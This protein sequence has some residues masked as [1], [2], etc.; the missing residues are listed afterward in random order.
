MTQAMKREWLIST[1]VPVYNV[2]SYI[3]QTLDSIIGQT[4]GFEQNV[5]L[6]IIDD[7]STDGSDEICKEFAERYPD[8]IEYVKQENAGVSTAR[9]NGLHLAQGEY[10]HFLDS[11]DVI[12]ND[13]YKRGI[14]FLEENKGA[15]DFV[16]AK[17]RF[18][19]GS[20]DA[21]PN[22]YKFERQRVINVDEEPDNP[23]MHVSSCIFV[24]NAVRN[25]A[26]DTKLKIAE[27]AKF[28]ADVLR[29]K[30][31]YGVL[32]KSALYY[33]KR[34][35]NS[36]AI[37]GQ[38]RNKSFYTVTPKRFLKHLL[39]SWSEGGRSTLYAQCVVLYDMHWRLDQKAQSVLTAEEE[40]EYKDQLRLLSKRL[41]D[42]TILKK[43]GA[44]V[45][46]KRYI[47]TQKYGD[48]WAG[49]LNEENGVYSMDDVPLF[50]TRSSVAYLDFLRSTDGDGMWV[51]EGYVTPGRIHP[52]DRIKVSVGSKSYDAE[53]VARPSREEVFLGDVV[54]E[55]GA[56]SILINIPKSDEKQLITLHYITSDGYSSRIPVQTNRFTGMSVLPLS[57]R[58]ERDTIFRKE[59]GS[60]AVYKHSKL[61]TVRF[62][63][64][65]LMVIM[66][67]WRIHT[68]KERL[69][70]L[71]RYN[72]KFL[73]RKQK[74]I[75]LIK[76][77]AFSVEAVAMIPRALL[78]RMAYRIVKPFVKR[79][80]WLVSDRGMA[81]GDNG[82]ALY[83]YIQQQ[84]NVPANVYFVIARKSLDYDRIKSIGGRVVDQNSL[85]Y[86][87]LFLLSS[88]VIS[89]QADVETTNPFIRQIDH[90]VDLFRFDFIFLQH[91]IIRHD[92][93]EWLNR[94]EKDIKLF[95][96]SAKKE[97]DSILD[98]PYFYSPEN[99]LL[100]GLP[101]YDYLENK[102]K[103]KLILAPTY[104]KNLVRMKTNKSGSRK[105][106]PLFKGTRYR[107]FYNDLMND[108]R[109]MDVLKQHNMSGELYLHPAFE[110]QTKDFIANEVFEVRQFPYNYSQAFREG[111]ILV[112]DHSSVIFDF[113]YLKKPIV[114][115]QFDS[116]TFFEGHTYN[117]S[118]FFI[119]ERD[120]FGPVT[121]SY[122]DL[123]TEIVWY[124]EHGC[125][126]DKK[127]IDRVDN[128]FYSHDK[129]NSMRVYE[130][131]LNLNSSKRV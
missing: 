70:R 119:D 125:V 45:M 49:R 105:Y 35:D 7:G 47:L 57:Y 93:S 85:R 82:E 14:K 55:G 90:Y 65:Y 114:Y 110:A 18:F 131:V 63:L 56:F 75:E 86:K 128:F 94:F 29:K 1:V 120:G 111:N 20:I 116:D 67:N 46:E 31:S 48:D 83:R 103:G 51:I 130:A 69:G 97:H 50:D 34:S 43:R 30:R 96:T 5:Q 60:I 74:I 126:M 11:D 32:A 101:R 79:P 121:H 71:R 40:N 58:N 107:N 41:D 28:V 19:D 89:S 80:I 95:V 64:G 37:N 100:S 9:N 78:L 3:A 88:K 27:D 104:R 68:L 129:N 112:S 92:L 106:N 102:P 123:I 8:N 108:D 36:S 72:L 109:I 24:S 15:V 76:P 91:G 12:S 73:S 21:H 38:F 22:N 26:F 4:V 59:K 44:S 66:A 42:R 53:W 25:E 2:R 98:L 127:Y 10:V 115:S 61:R 81:A 113:A 118:D 54:N 33:R 77:F 99:V 16:A 117:E 62:E 87:L 84:K 39:D 122:E 6:I 124:V 52:K 23:I 17:I 13:F